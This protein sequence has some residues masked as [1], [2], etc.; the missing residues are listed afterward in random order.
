MADT[1]DSGEGFG[2]L[3]GLQSEDQ[4]EGRAK[5]SFVATERHLNPHGTVHGGAIA[6]LCDTAMGMAV[7]SGASPEASRP[8]TI[9]MKITYLEPSAPGDVVATAQVRKRGRRIT[10]VE[11]EVTQENEVV[12]LAI[13]TFTTI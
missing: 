5:V 10:V 6:S 3:L 13:G 4:G 9:E 11:T 8:V 12:A 2:E 1:H 7:I